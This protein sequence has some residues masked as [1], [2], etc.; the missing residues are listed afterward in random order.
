MN[1]K[2]IK[3]KD[4]S[5]VFYNIVLGVLNMRYFKSQN[6]AHE[7]EREREHFVVVAEL[8]S[9]LKMMI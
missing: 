6:I 2:D 8:C 4:I 5:N 1:P 9:I 7:R 3:M